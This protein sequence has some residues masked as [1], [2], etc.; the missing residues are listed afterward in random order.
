[1]NNKQPTM[2]VRI[3]GEIDAGADRKSGPHND[4]LPD[5]P[6]YTPAGSEVTGPIVLPL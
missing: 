3:I 5:V 6:R 1:M 2:T 4:G